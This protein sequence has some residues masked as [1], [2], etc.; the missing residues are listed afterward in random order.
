VNAK[1]Q[2]LTIKLSGIGPSAPVVAETLV[3]AG[4]DNPAKIRKASNKDLE[5]IDGIG[6]VTREAI[7]KRLPARS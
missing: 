6:K 3:K 7:R 5:A 4:L 1:I 2:K